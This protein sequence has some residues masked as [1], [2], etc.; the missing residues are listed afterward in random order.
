MK[1]LGALG[2]IYDKY[3]ISKRLAKPAVRLECLLR[4][5]GSTNVQIKIFQQ[6]RVCLWELW[7]VEISYGH[8]QIESRL[9]LESISI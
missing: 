2:G 9:M 5:E 7:R 3:S 4:G 6:K 8:C 1:G